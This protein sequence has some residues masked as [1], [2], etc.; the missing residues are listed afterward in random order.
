VLRLSFL[1]GEP[2]PYVALMLSVLDPVTI[3][4][5]QLLISLVCVV[6]NTNILE[7]IH[8]VVHLVIRHFV[9]NF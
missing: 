3:L 2:M 5:Y 1:A 8:L 9:C 6:T 4:Y 7:Y